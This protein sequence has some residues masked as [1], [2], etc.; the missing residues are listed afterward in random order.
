MLIQQH[1]IL[2]MEVSINEFHLKSTALI[3]IDV[4]VIGMN[5]VY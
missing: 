3:V 4:R 2:N 1:I 5:E